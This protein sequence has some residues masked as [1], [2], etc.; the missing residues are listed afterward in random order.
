MA[1]QGWMRAA[2]WDREQTVEILQQAYAEGRLEP[3]EL[4]QRTDTA[5]RA[6]TIGEL[7]GLIVDIP[8]T[9]PAARLPS[10]QPWPA[11]ARPQRRPARQSPRASLLLLLAA[12]VCVLIGAALSNTAV[13]AVALM[14]GLG[15]AILRQVD[16]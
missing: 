5:L 6:K 7:R 10:D 14:A 4:D 16:R 11:A 3:A 9:G 15:T 8:R 12:A 13:I 2:I 1:V